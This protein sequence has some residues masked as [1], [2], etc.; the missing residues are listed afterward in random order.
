MCT[1]VAL[2]PPQRF[3]N[4]SISH[5]LLLISITD[6]AWEQACMSDPVA[7][8]LLWWPLV[9]G[10]SQEWGTW[11]E[12]DQGCCLQ[13][14]CTEHASV[15]SL[16][17]KKKFYNH[18]KGQDLQSLERAC[19]IDFHLHIIS[20]PR[21]GMPKANWKVILFT[22]IRRFLLPAIHRLS[23]SLDSALLKPHN[24]IGTM[25]PL[26]HQTSSVVPVKSV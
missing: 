4:D 23:F 17:L 16:L 21:Y 26:D 6:L 8:G 15:T 9:E 10:R 25:V 1:T 22:D 2:F 13:N 7:S 5:W 14:Y 24:P 18:F 3:R 12:K 19:Y 11:A 20:T